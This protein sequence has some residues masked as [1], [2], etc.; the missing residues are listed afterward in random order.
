MVMGIIDL[1]DNPVGCLTSLAGQPGERQHVQ[2]PY[3]RHDNERVCG[4]LPHHPSLSD[5]SGIVNHR[6]KGATGPRPSNQFGLQSAT[7]V[8]PDKLHK[9]RPQHPAASVSAAVHNSFLSV[10][11]FHSGPAHTLITHLI[12]GRRQKKRA[13]AQGNLLTKPFV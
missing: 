9:M 3:N 5:F 7:P 13:F 8:K 10:L 1:F 2:I 12:E 6:N 11:S 4:I